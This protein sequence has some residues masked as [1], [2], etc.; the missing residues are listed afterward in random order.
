MQI[1]LILTGKTENIFLKNEI[2]E[3]FV[4][5]HNVIDDNTFIIENCLPDEESKLG[6]ILIFSN[7]NIS[8]TFSLYEINWNFNK[9]LQ[10][11]KFTT[12]GSLH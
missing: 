12:L 8:F 7:S 9:S 4:D 2:S 11:A 10:N 6:N 5:I 1:K 3:Y